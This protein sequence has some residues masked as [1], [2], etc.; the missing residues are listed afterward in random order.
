MLLTTM[1]EVSTSTMMQKREIKANK[2]EKGE[3]FKV[4]MMINGT[5]RN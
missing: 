4:V 3:D 1:L 5:S 2:I